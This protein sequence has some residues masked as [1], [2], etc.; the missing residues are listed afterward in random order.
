[1]ITQVL[2]HPDSALSARGVTALGECYKQLNSSVGEFGTATLQ[3]ATNAIEST[4]RGDRI[5]RATDK[6]LQGLDIV[7]DRLAGQ[8]KGEL[9]AAAFR[10]T[11]I[12]RVQVQVQ[13][14]TCNLLTGRAA[15][16]AQ[17]VS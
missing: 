11:P 13:T 17:H 10:N 16:L 4:S 15:Q 8:I 3:A 2:T 12:P 7:R 14:A 6:I 5:Y 1:V 9:E